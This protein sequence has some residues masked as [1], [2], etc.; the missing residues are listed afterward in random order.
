MFFSATPYTVSYAYPGSV[1]RTVLVSVKSVTLSGGYVWKPSRHE[2]CRVLRIV[3]E[4][5][6]NDH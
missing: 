4:H 5:R 2:T 6:K 3:P 1:P